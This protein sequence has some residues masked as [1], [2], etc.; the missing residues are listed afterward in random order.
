VAAAEL[1]T[2]SGLCDSWQLASCIPLANWVVVGELYTVSE[3]C[4]SWQ[5]VWQ[6]ASCGSW[7]ALW[8]LASCVAVGKLHTTVDKPYIAGEL[9]GRWQAVWQCDVWW[10]WRPVP[11][12]H[13]RQA[14]WQLANCGSW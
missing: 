7:E 4:H 8:P 2:F 11:V 14:L 6:L 5:A 13:R 10:A 3:L 9:C 12:A 1:Y